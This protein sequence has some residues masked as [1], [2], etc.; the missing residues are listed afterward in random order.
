[1]RRQVRMR[2]APPPLSCG[3]GH[4]EASRSSSH[5]VAL[6]LAYSPGC[7]GLVRSV[8]RALAGWGATR[9]P[10]DVVPAV[11]S[12]LTISDA[13]V[14]C[15]DSQSLPR[16]SRARWLAG[17]QSPCSWPPCMLLTSG[18]KARTRLMEPIWCAGW[19]GQRVARPPQRRLP[20]GQPPQRVAR[21]AR[22]PR[23]SAAFIR[24]PAL[25]ECPS[26]NRSTAR[27]GPAGWA[28]P[29]SA[30]A[31]PTAGRRLNLLQG[32][33]AAPRRRRP[34]RPRTRAPHPAHPTPPPTNARAASTCPSWRA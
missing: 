8:S 2:H 9:L 34:P 3:P 12:T 22:A 18:H 6:I 15:I 14:R 26:S 23:C 4:V 1:M 19:R 11:N 21:S 24:P 28:A 5:C 16:L 7:H 17:L 20:V 33:T 29:P 32:R 27:S 13:S 31:A 25:R 30:P 10:R